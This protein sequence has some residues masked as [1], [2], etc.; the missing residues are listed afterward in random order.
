MGSLGY[1]L[2]SIM[3]RLNYDDPTYFFYIEN[4]APFQITLTLEKNGKKEQFEE[5]EQY[6]EQTLLADLFK[7]IEKGKDP[8]DQCKTV[9][10]LQRLLKI[11]KKEGKNGKD[12]K[13]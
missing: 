9:K 1:N 11:N 10:G 2:G 8:C 7:D 6:G 4:S 3:V 13:I 12:S 5:S